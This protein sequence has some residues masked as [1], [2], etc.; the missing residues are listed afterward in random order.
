M[1]HVD[2]SG[3]RDGSPV[4]RAGVASE[5]GRALNELVTIAPNDVRD[6]VFD[7]IMAHC[8]SIRGYAAVLPE[9]EAMLIAGSVAQRLMQSRDEFPQKPSKA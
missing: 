3:E 7:E 1:S 9:F 6:I 2:C 4:S 8:D 5:A